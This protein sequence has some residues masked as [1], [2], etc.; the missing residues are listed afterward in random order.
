MAGAWNYARKAAR[1][2]VISGGLGFPP[3]AKVH[4]IERDAEYIRRDKSELRCA[5]TDHADDRAID[6]RQNPAFPTALAQQNGGNNSK[7]TR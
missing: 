6:A 2:H 7:N 4:R 1:M 5:E 3:G